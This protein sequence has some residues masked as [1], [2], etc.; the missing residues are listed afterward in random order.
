[1]ASKKRPTKGRASQKRSRV[2][3]RANLNDANRAQKVRRAA[4]VAG[5]ILVA[6][7]AAVITA[8][9]TPY[10]SD[11]ALLSNV[12]AQKRQDASDRLGKGGS[13]QA[14]KLL[15]ELSGKHSAVTRAGLVRA[16]SKLP[17]AAE[18]VRSLRVLLAHENP[19]VCASAGFILQKATKARDKLIPE[20]VAVVS[21]GDQ[22]DGVKAI[23]VRA[24]KGA[25]GDGAKTVEAVAS[26]GSGLTRLAA[27]RTLGHIPTTG[28]AK[29][30]AIAADAKR[31][32]RDRA[33]AMRSLGEV[34]GSNASSATSEL[35]TLVKSS[36]GFVR[37]HAT[38]A[39]GARGETGSVSTFVTMAKDKDARVRVEALRAIQKAKAVKSE[40]DTV[41]TLLSDSDV[42]VQELALRLA[43]S[44]KPWDLSDI[45]S[46]LVS[47]LGSKNFKIRLGSALALAAYGDKGGLDTMKT[48]KDST[49]K[50]VA[51]QAKAAYDLIDKIEE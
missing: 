37:E 17:V 9:P 1:M 27:I 23:A 42:R 48:D 49:T 36:S 22:L 13:S 47:E 5:V 38:A 45:K 44:D 4:P 16:L 19:N 10:E 2:R 30:A 21:D 43:A 50:S 6:L 20:I 35:K 32:D 39:L 24:L 18:H 14:T 31:E 12:D 34:T 51:A 11:L 33:L 15:L 41:K 29:L 46:T 28:P 40:K 8:A 25:T 26:T 3:V 7:V